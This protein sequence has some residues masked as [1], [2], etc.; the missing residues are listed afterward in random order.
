M[1]FLPDSYRIEIDWSYVNDCF[2]IRV[3]ESDPD[4]GDCTIPRPE[5]SK[6]TGFLEDELKAIGKLLDQEQMED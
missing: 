4:T 5:L 6:K 3:F 2:Q 1:K